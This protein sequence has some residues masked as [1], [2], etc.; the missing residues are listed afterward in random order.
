[1]SQ[2]LFDS[3]ECGRAGLP[4]TAQG[5][6]TVQYLVLGFEYRAGSYLDRRPYQDYL[7]EDV[8]GIVED[9]HTSEAS[10]LP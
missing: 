4:L 2:L 6:R 1:M 8:Q 10:V 3:R 5:Q 9:V 7:D